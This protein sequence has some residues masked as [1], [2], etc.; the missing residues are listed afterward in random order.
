MWI[1]QRAPSVSRRRRAPLSEGAE[2]SGVD[3]WPHSIL[4][5]RCG[6]IV[7]GVV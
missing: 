7:G 2:C 5:Q 6:E 4:S 3:G 1:V